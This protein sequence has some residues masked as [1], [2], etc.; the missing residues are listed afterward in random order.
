MST[1]TS[2]SGVVRARHK[3]T[4]ICIA[5]AW[6][7]A[8]TVA[9]GADLR[10]PHLKPGLWVFDSTGVGHEQEGPTTDR[11]CVD[12]TS[13]QLTNETMAGINVPR[14]LEKLCTRVQ[15]SVGNKVVVDLQCPQLG[16]HVNGRVTSRSVTTFYGDRAT[17]IE[18]ED[19][20]RPPFV[21]M[22][23]VRVW[24]D[25]KW[26]GPCPADMQPGDVLHK[27]PRMPSEMRLNLLPGNNGHLLPPN[28]GQ[29]PTIIRGTTVSG[30]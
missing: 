1:I 8:N 9:I 3:L 6:A 25:G 26:V 14:G 24:G 2:A 30:R 18:R 5:A 23:D 7:A 12:S 21:G 4:L 16:P 10:F 22:T 19:H 13:D 17:H 29:S 15:Q 20:Y 27:S 28:N 11:V